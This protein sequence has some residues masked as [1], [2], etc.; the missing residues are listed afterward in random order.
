MNHW[1]LSPL[2]IV[3]LLVTACTHDPSPE[4]F[5]APVFEQVSM[6]ESVAG[7]VTF[8]CR[9]SSMS[10]LTEYGLYVTT[11][12]EESD[13]AWTKVQGTKTA[14]DAFI[15]RMKEVE[16]GRTYAYRLYIGN[17]REEVQSA[18]NYYTVPE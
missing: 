2:L 14:S 10:Q 8:T 11:E 18:T 1:H 3:S 17:G 12:W 16:P 7:E 9:M 15:V 6:D 4:P 5:L 13:S